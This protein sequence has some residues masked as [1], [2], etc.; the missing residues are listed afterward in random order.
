MQFDSWPCNSY[1]LFI[2]CFSYPVTESNL[3]FAGIMLLG[4]ILLSLTM[5]FFPKYGAHAWFKGPDTYN[6]L[7]MD[8]SQVC[9]WIM[10]MVSR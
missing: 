10:G 6:K 8:S 9:G 3:N 7:G 1:F 4:V 2:P 5:F